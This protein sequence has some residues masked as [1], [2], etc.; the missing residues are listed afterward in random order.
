MLENDFK[1][2]REKAIT[3]KKI[4]IF[5]NKYTLY[6]DKEIMTQEVYKRQE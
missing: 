4:W 5:I 3:V 2:N 1:M 6:D